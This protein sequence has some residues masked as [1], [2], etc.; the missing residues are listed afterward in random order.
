M[1]NRT[2]NRHEAARRAQIIRAKNCE[3]EITVERRVDRRGGDA[4]HTVN[5]LHC[6]ITLLVGRSVMRNG[7]RHRFP[8]HYTRAGKQ[9]ADASPNVT[10]MEAPDA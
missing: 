6:N 5:C 9:W 3:H 2:A 1:P 10:N 7:T 8:M 4:Y